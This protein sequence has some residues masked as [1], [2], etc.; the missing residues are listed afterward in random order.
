MRVKFTYA[1]L[2]LLN[3]AIKSF[4]ISDIVDNEFLENT[5][6]ALINKTLINFITNFD[7]IRV[8]CE[9]PL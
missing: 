9:A 6:I 2:S 5:I 8:A 1:T 3:Y 4:F 7:L